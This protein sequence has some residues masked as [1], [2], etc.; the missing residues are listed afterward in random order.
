VIA[1]LPPAGQRID[2][3]GA[4][5]AFEGDRGPRLL[6]QARVPG[7]PG[8]TLLARWVVRDSAGREVARGEQPPGI[9]ACDPAAA[10]LAEFDADLPPGRYEVAVS[11]RDARLRRG[12]YRTRLAL[13]PA[14][15]TIA[16]SD[17]VLCCG[18]PSLVGDRSVRIE[19]DMDATVA[20][21][22]P[23]VAYF[24]IYRLARDWDGVSRFR[25]EYE[26]KRRADER[27]PRAIR[28]AE[29]R[30]PVDRWVSRDETHMGGTRRQFVRVQ[31]ASIA[32]GR[33]QLR[34]RVHDL[35]AGADAE[36]T[37]EFVRE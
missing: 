21:N 1:T 10:R 14:S 34:V 4:V 33:Y 23:L 3:R 32:P 9:S 25:Y 30:P 27:D 13:A 29:R 2:L 36:R 22:R 16:L 19:A 8:D 31:T 17:L 26:V 24:E 20:G 37:A 12:L 5:S 11:V 15:A 18:D 7:A 35:I 28:D 6:V